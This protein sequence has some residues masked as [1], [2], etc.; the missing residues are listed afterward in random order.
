MLP[1]WLHWESSISPKTLNLIPPIK[2][3]CDTKL[4]S[5]FTYV[6]SSM[7]C[8]AI[9]VEYSCGVCLICFILFITGFVESAQA[10]GLASHNHRVLYFNHGVIMMLPI[11]FRFLKRYPFLSGIHDIITVI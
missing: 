11:L 6:T 5:Y 8:F 10:L 4:S 3:E 7:C 1:L 9:G 2:K